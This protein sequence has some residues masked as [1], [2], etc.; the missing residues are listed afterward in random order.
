[1]LEVISPN[2]VSAEGRVIVAAL[3]NPRVVTEVLNQIWASPV[4]TQ[5][6]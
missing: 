1:V 5:I 4:K 3:G 2:F 6:V